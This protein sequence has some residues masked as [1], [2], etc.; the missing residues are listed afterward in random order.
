MCVTVQC[1]LFP[2]SP[3]DSVLVSS[4][5][6]LLCW[7]LQKRSSK[8]TRSFC[9][10]RKTERI[11]VRAAFL[12][13]LLLLFVHFFSLADLCP[14]SSTS[15]HHQDLPLHGL[16]DGEARWP[17]GTSPAR[18]GLHGLLSGQQQLRWGVTPTS[19]TPWQLPSPQHPPPLFYIHVHT[20]D[21]CPCT[22]APHHQNISKT[23]GVIFSSSF[24][25]SWFSMRFF[26][27]WYQFHVTQTPLP[28]PPLSLFPRE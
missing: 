3:S 16:W 6:W 21:T 9:G 4:S 14:V 26:W 17:H 24:T 12:L 7:S 11:E 13:L 22:T 25:N 28:L 23:E 1:F 10:S 18:S 2:D 5:G 20:P 19:S 8:L 27:E 15:V